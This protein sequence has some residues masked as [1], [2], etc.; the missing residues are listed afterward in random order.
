MS[1][2][3][4]IYF[5]YKIKIILQQSKKKYAFFGYYPTRQVP[6]YFLYIFKNQYLKKYVQKSHFIHDLK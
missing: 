5:L 6:T 2:S 3:K 4:D 1:E